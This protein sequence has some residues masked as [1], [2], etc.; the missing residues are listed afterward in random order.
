M[1]NCSFYENNKETN[2]LSNL[3]Y[4]L[5]PLKVYVQLEVIPSIINFILISYYRFIKYLHILW[6][7]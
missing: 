4:P 1:N 7:A 6:N 2:Q 5:A 3:L